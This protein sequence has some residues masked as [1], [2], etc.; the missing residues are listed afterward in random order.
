MEGLDDKD[1][2][3]INQ[4]IRANRKLM[5][6]AD[7]RRVVGA[8]IVMTIGAAF[9]AVLEDTPLEDTVL[10]ILE[11]INADDDLEGFALEFIRRFDTSYPKVPDE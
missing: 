3:I 11:D 8:I 9:Q 10:D 2:E 5:A 4:G 7:N 6:L 1:I